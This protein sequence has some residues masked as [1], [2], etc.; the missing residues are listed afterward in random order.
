MK[1]IAVSELGEQIII[2]N[3]RCEIRE[4]PTQR[5]KN[6]EGLISNLPQH[7]DVA[8]TDVWESEVN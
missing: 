2:K 5:N 1:G 4:C 8:E 7:R 6:L 3:W